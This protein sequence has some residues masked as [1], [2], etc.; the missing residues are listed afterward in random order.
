M[1][2]PRLAALAIAGAIMLLAGCGSSTPSAA[3]SPSGGGAA[4]TAAPPSSTPMET[5]APTE[6]QTPAPTEPPEYQ[7][8]E[9]LRVG[10]CYQPVEDVDDQSLLAAIIVPCE[11]PHLAEVFGVDDLEGGPDA[12]FPGVDVIDDDAIDICD[13]AFEAYVGVALD[14]S[15]YSYVY[16]TPTEQS[17]AGGDRV[18]M[19]SV[20]DRGREL[21]GSVQGTER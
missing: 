20:D 10:D 12:P 21:E 11:Q 5:P 17:W 1:V 9:D 6:T 19:C 7:A 8:T 14:N 2:G 16:Y 15:R 13:A 3:A 4:A 18:V